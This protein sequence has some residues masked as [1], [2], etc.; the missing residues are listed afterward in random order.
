[1]S[2]L[3]ITSL[4]NPDPPGSN[5]SVVLP[6][7][8]QNPAL[9]SPTT[10]L[11][12]EP[13]EH[14]Q[15]PPQQHT[16]HLLQF[17]DSRSFA[18]SS[19][20][21]VSKPQR[22][23]QQIPSRMVVVASGAATREPGSVPKI[24]PKGDINFWPHE[25]VDDESRRM[26]HMFHIDTLGSIRDS[27]QHIPYNSGK[28]DFFEKTGRESLEVFYYNF[29]IDGNDTEYTVRWDYN[30][31]LVRMTDFFKALNYPKTAPAKML[32][33]NEGLK[34]IT[35]S[36][37]G[38][39]IKAQGYW[40]PYNCAKAICATFCHRIAGALIPLFGPGFPSMC[41][42][43]E[44]PE[45]GRWVIDPAIIAESRAE[46]ERYKRMYLSLASSSVP[47]PTSPESSTASSPRR[48]MGRRQRIYD[49][50]CSYH[51]AGA[52]SHPR[53]GYLART[54]PS[55]RPIIT[56]FDDGNRSRGH[57]IGSGGPFDDG[58]RFDERLGNHRSYSRD[59]M[60][61]R[62]G[63]P[64]GID[65][66]REHSYPTVS[67]S[68]TSLYYD[69]RQGYKHQ[70]GS[71]S[72]TAPSTPTY[73]GEQHHSGWTTANPRYPA[74][75]SSD[76]KERAELGG[77]SSHSHCRS[78]PANNIGTGANPMLS[79]IPRCS[80]MP[81][82]D[83]RERPSTGPSHYPP[84][85]PP[86]DAVRAV[87]DPPRL[88]HPNQPATIHR[89]SDTTYFVGPSHSSPSPRP[90]WSPAKPPSLGS[91]NATATT[92][93]QHSKP[94]QRQPQRGDTSDIRSTA[95]MAVA[96]CAAQREQELNQHPTRPSLPPPRR[97]DIRFFSDPEPPTLSPN[98][99]GDRS[100]QD[101]KQFRD[102]GADSNAA[103]LLLNL[104]VRDRD[105]KETSTT[106]GTSAHDEGSHNCAADSHDGSA[107]EDGDGDDAVR[108]GSS[109]AASRRK[110]KESKDSTRRRSK[111]RRGGSFASSGK[112]LA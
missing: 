76:M 23:R 56:G 106:S 7:L 52:T 50:V 21:Q 84:A 71:W 105:G 90:S 45:F 36:I 5:T 22:Q 108:E 81:W 67:S 29:K 62:H 34:T 18:P 57:P 112:I 49:R 73:G 9:P 4:L 38:G 92:A 1:M 89:S 78:Q 80:P 2:M 100:C 75:E 99:P 51:T 69:R 94:I 68:S 14:R 42:P 77:G 46:A 44:S 39:S 35:P 86:F 59:W 110:R 95:V 30:V 83:G 70:Q 55:V 20:P 107:N 103:L 28:K 87:A 58:Y 10:S 79:A 37:T 13:H 91:T 98:S 27:C 16:S 31:G 65:N 33:Q 96:M 25:N 63:S 12:E 6:R 97:P 26:I 64:S 109:W 104:S 15:V 74:Y 32:N 61:K 41:M 24:K 19:S 47:S 54:R 66:E 17:Q 93:K 48:L 85:R 101:R 8:R 43:P 88:P 82:N 53:E 11:I 111:R 40:M 72:A 3:A 60:S 102:G